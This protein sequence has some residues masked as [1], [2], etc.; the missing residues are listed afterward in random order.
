MHRVRSHEEQRIAVGREKRRLRRI[1]PSILQNMLSSSSLSL[2]VNRTSN[3]DQTKIKRKDI[4]VAYYISHLLV[5]FGHAQ[6][7]P[8]HSFSLCKMLFS[9]AATTVFIL[10][11]FLLLLSEIVKLT[12]ISDLKL[13]ANIIGVICMHLVG[14][15]KWCYCIKE[16]HQIVD[17]AIKLEKCHVLCQQIDNSE[18]GCRVYKNEMEYARRYSSY[19]IYGWTC[20]CIYGVLHWCLNPFLLR[21]WAVKQ[22][23]ST[24]HTIIKRNLPFIGWYPFNIDDIHNYIYLYFMQIIGGISSALGIVCFDTFYV[25]MLMIVCAQFQYINTMLTRINFDNVPNTE[26]TCILDRKL[27]NCVNCHTEIIQFLKILQTFCSPAMF[28]QCVETLVLICLVSFEAST[29]KIAFDMESIFKLWTLLEYFLCAS[30]QLYF[31][32]FFA[33][34]LE[35]LGLQIAHSVYFCGWEPMIFNERTDQSTN[36]FGKQ[37]KYCNINRSVQMIMVRAQKPIVLTGGPFYIL[38]LETFRVI[39][40]LAMSNSVMLRTISDTILDE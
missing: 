37:L 6:I 15:I 19:F 13:F 2:F 38:S 40:S 27:K 30:V 20:T 1:D 33:T 16:K 9:T 31:F 11:N 3:D 32:C 14:L 36:S 26:A 25:T 17:I 28:M 23:D 18:E 12:M 21:T 34:Q 24:N 39:I 4:S 5:I 10:G 22:M 35:H 8:V 7:W 29:I